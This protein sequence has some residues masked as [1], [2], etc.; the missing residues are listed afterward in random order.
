VAGGAGGSATRQAAVVLDDERLKQGN[1]VFGKDYFDELLER[2]REI[3]LSKLV[4][5]EVR[6]QYEI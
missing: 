1:Q 2:I 3:L 5:G 6:I 4:S